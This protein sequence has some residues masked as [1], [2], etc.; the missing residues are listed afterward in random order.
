MKWAGNAG[1]MQSV[2]GC[3]KSSPLALPDLNDSDENDTS[4]MSPSDSDK[5][6]RRSGSEDT[7]ESTTTES[8]GSAASSPA[9]AGGSEG[10]RANA[11]LTVEQKRETRRKCVLP[12]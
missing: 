4:A 2:K 3:G 1:D 8:A 10:K 6:R 5:K 11:K 12:K 9:P 7:G